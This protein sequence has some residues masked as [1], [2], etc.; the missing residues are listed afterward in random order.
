MRKEMFAKMVS[1]FKLQGSAAM[2]MRSAEM[3]E[4]EFY[5]EKSPFFCVHLEAACREI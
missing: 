4:V 5:C 1:V 2:R 3:I